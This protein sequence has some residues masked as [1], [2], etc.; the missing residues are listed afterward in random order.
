MDCKYLVFI[1]FILV[2][3]LRSDIFNWCIPWQ[4]SRRC[5]T[6]KTE[7]IRTKY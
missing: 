6:T 1:I 7:Q 2:K 4:R 5:E 3:D